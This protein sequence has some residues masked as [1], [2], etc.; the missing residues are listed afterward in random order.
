M[1]QTCSA[2][3]VRTRTHILTSQTKALYFIIYFTSKALEGIHRR[4]FQETR[5]APH[6]KMENVFLYIHNSFIKTLT[7]S[8]LYRN[9]DC[10]VLQNV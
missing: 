8:G 1:Q 2:G 7:F 9:K 4:Q 10:M 5:G 3:C 6:L